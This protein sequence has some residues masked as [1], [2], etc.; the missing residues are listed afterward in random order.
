MLK[1][2]LRHAAAAVLACAT[3]AALAAP[4]QWASAS[5]GNDHWYERIITAAG[6]GYT[7]DGALADAPT[8]SWLGMGGYVAT[9]TSQG[10]QNFLVATFGT[11]AAWLGGNDRQTE[12]TWQWVNGPEAG[13]VFHV[14]GAPAQ[15]GYSAWGGGEPN[16]CCSGEDDLVYGYFGDPGATWNDH[17]SPSWPTQLYTYLIEYNGQPNNNVPEPTTLALVGSAL[18]MAGLRRRPRRS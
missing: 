12:G 16:D 3:G 13:Q 4:V 7:Y 17:G 8:R 11:A 10:E 2:I 15:P 14:V 18:L 6:G 9:V 1:P 5:G